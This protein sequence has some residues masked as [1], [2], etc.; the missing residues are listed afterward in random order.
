MQYLVKPMPMYAVH[1]E[2]EELFVVLEGSGTMNL[3]ATLVNPRRGNGATTMIADTATGGTDH[4]LTKGDMFI[5][6]MNTAR[7]VTQGIAGGAYSL[8]RR[9]ILGIRSSYIASNSGRGLQSRWLKK[10]LDVIK[11]RYAALAEKARDEAEI[12]SPHDSGPTAAPENN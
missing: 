2:E 9:S 12:S 7:C 1:Q 3:G 8:S 10:D 5:V 4:K 6:P 11:I